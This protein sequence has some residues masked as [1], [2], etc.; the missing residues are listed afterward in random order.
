[1]IA[2]KHIDQETTRASLSSPLRSKDSS[3]KTGPTLALT[4]PSGGI[5]KTIKNLN[6]VYNATFPLFTEK[7]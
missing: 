7:K 2:H 6:D 4:S 1:M 3:P 5:S